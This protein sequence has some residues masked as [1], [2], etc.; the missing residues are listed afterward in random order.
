MPIYLKK[1]PRHP[2]RK[3][4]SHRARQNMATRWGAAEWDTWKEV[5][6]II[7]QKIL[8]GEAPGGA[9]AVAPAVRVTTGGVPSLD[10][11]PPGT[12]RVRPKPGPGPKVAVPVKKRASKP[13]GSKSTSGASGAKPFGKAPVPGGLY[14]RIVKSVGGRYKACPGIDLDAY[15]VERE[16][17]IDPATG[18]QVYTEGG[19]PRT[20]RVGPTKYEQ[21]LTELGLTPKKAEKLEKKM[22]KAGVLQTKREGSHGHAARAQALEM[23]HA[24]KGF[25]CP[26]KPN[27][28]FRRHRRPPHRQW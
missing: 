6:E 12:A 15:E 1:A 25:S 14:G 11:G 7:Q 23:L 24:V 20:R 10:I 4:R 21:V 17:V 28:R 13:G 18:E 26:V 2:R 27:P 3:R 9:A 5:P 19:Y 16:P 8:A 22:K